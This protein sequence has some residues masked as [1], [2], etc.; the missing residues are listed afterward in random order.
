MSP[1]RSC[2]RPRRPQVIPVDDRSGCSKT[3]RVVPR[4]IA[5][6]GEVSLGGI[7]TECRTFENH[8]PPWRSIL[9]CGHMYQACT[10][11][12]PNVWRMLNMLF[13]STFTLQYLLTS[14]RSFDSFSF[15]FSSFNLAPFFIL[16]FVVFRPLRLSAR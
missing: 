7:I 1:R 4:S 14:C 13:V 15:H 2:E 8:P 12:H 3:L 16:V 10:T 5:P 9:S 6:A 11:C